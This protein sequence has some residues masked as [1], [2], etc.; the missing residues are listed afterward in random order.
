M[1]KKIIISIEGNIGVGKSSFIELL[2]KNLNEEKYEYIPEPVDE[3]L[4]LK[5]ENGKNL[6]Q[7]FYEDKK[8]WGYTFQNIAYLTRMNKIIDAIQKSNKDFIILDR[9]LSAD[10]NTFTKMLYEEGS[11]NELE[12]N[13]YNMWNNFFDQKFGKDIEHLIVYL[14]CDPEISYERSKKRNRNEE[15][16]IPLEYFKKL[17]KYHED[18][19]MRKEK[20][21]PSGIHR[22]LI[23]NSNK[24]FIKD[25]EYFKKMLIEFKDF[26]W[27]TQV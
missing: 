26:Y 15:K 9:S 13:A 5:D 8:R 6:L 17:N 10:L 19:L 24:D 7:T 3:W 12:W 25:E 21:S 4:S 11:M 18:W 1:N 23:L 27:L 20:V 16:E 2:K 14:R 22:I